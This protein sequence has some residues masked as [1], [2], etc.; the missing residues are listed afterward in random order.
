MKPGPEIALVPVDGG[1][2]ALTHRPKK[3]DFRALRALGVTHVITLLNDN[4]GAQSLGAIAANE[5]L[6]WIWCPLKGADINAP[7]DA[8]RAALKDGKAALAAG[9]AVIVHC[10]A[11]IHRTGMFG[12][13]LLRVAGLD[14]DAA[15][16]KLHELRAVTAEGVGSDRLDWGDRI[17]EA[18]VRDG[19]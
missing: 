6:S 2:L 8:V 13:A 19:V 18:F 7:L 14:R 9:G 10:S 11:G 4:E 12:Y 15:L 1:R 5:G 16:E 3:T 17:A